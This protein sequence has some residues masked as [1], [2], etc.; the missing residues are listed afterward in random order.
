MA[1][2]NQGARHTATDENGGKQ[3]GEF[4]VQRKLPMRQYGS[5]LEIPA[6][7][8]L[9]VVAICPWRELMHV[10]KNGGV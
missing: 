9:L 5:N 1:P 4:G 3:W 6:A 8:E 7:Q 10:L 2:I